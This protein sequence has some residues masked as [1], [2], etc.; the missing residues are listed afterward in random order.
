MRSVV[1]GCE[2]NTGKGM[3]DLILLLSIGSLTLLNVLAFRLFSKE[4]LETRK[5]IISVNHRLFWARR[6]E[7]KLLKMIRKI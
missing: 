7:L 3:N 1:G 5:H 2:R 6:R 4:L